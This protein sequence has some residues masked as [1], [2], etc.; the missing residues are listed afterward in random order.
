M[1][2]QQQQNKNNTIELSLNE[3]QNIDLARLTSLINK[4]IDDL[5]LDG[6]HEKFAVTNA[7]K[8]YARRQELYTVVCA[9]LPREL[10]EALR[11]QLKKDNV[12]IV[13]FVKTAAQ[14]YLQVYSQNAKNKED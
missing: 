3:L 6:E 12:A 10:G 14:I 7:K 11:A 5:D 8:K 13:D 4:K 2:K 1:N 9:Y